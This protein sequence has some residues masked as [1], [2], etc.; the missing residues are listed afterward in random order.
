MNLLDAF[1]SAVR[2]TPAK[3]FLRDRGASIS[4]ADMQRRSQRAAAVLQAQGVGRGDTVALMCL[5]TPGF[6]EALFGAWRPGRRAGA[7]QPQAAGARAA[8]HPRPRAVQG[9][10]V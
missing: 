6:V 3:A 9:P 10:G 8:V 4:Y 7:R 1:D 5:N 2:K